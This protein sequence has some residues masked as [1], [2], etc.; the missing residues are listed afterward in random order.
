MSSSCGR[1][2]LV[3]KPPEGLYCGFYSWDQHHNVPYEAVIL[4]ILKTIKLC[5]ELCEQIILFN[6]T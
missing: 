2:F 6:I 4:L 1:S 5:G 3:V